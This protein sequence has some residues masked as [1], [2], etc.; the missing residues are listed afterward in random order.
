ML[1]RS[2]LGEREMVTG[3][4]FLCTIPCAFKKDS[5]CSISKAICLTSLQL[6]NNKEYGK[7]EKTDLT[8]KYYLW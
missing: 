6:K 8:K 4:K 2:T 3:D 5:P 1:M 7:K